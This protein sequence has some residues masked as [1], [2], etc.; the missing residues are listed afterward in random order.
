M[1]RSWFRALLLRRVQV[2]FLLILQLCFLFFIFQNESFIAQVLR[3]V[4]HIISGFLVLYII[5]KKDKGA[6][7][8]IWIFLILLFP[9]F[10]SLLYIL[11]NFQASTRKFEQKI[12]Q[13][14]QK[15]RTL[16]GLP[17]S[18]EKSAYYEAPAHIP[19]IRYLKYAGF[20]V[21]DDTQTEYLSPGEKFFPIFLEELKKA[22][23]YIFI[24]YF[25]I[26]EGLMWQSILDILKEKVSQ[27]VEVRVIYDDIGCFL[28]LPKDYAMQLK[29]IGI[30]CEVFNPFRPVLTAIQNNRDHRKI[31]VIDGKV[32]FTGGLNLS[33][34]YINTYEKHGYWKDAVIQIKGKAAWSLTLMFLEMWELCCGIPDDIEC[35]FP[36]NKVDERIES[37][38]FV[39]PYSDS[40]VDNENVGEHVYLQI[41][42][43]AKDYVYICTPY[44]IVDDSMV[45]A[46]CLAA[47]SGV[48]VRIITPH[49]YDKALI[50]LT[51][52]SFYRELIYGGVKI[53]EY[54]KG[55]MHSKIF[56]SDDQIATVGTTN[57][58]FRSLHLHFE[59]GVWMYNS[60][61]VLQIKKDYFDTLNECTQI[62]LEECIERL[63]IRVFQEILRIFAPLM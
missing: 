10:G 16:Y 14:G 51:T 57:L 53:Y 26:K 52:R 13:I 18:A 54:S 49:I 38:G 3:S 50:H 23:K 41:I 12:F 29:N 1:K 59:C 11:Y 34:E 7:K 55:F 30:K 62:T 28:A 36:K 21:Y 24:E 27:G 60:K 31:T 44:L 45:S 25:I 43:N 61:A 42:N 2:L 20:P 37:D 46:L 15:N 47:K 48:D 40:P 56:V 35:F 6:N 63:P 22:Q 9:L 32:A 4:V 58:D 8:V 5:S 39:Q 17:G 33:D 19:Q